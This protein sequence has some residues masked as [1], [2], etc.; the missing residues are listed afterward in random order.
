MPYPADVLGMETRRERFAGVGT[1]DGE[2]R[3]VTR[4]ASDLG[5]A[6]DAQELLYY[7]V[8]DLLALSDCL[9]GH[10]G[11]VR[12]FPWPSS[13]HPN[14]RWM[15]AGIA[16]PG[17]TSGKELAMD[18]AEPVRARRFALQY[19]GMRGDEHWYTVVDVR[20]GRRWG[21]YQ[22]H[23]ARH[24]IANDGLWLDGGV[25]AMGGMTRG[26]LVRLWRRA[27]ALLL[28]CS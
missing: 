11:H 1:W 25:P 18:E 19:E 21:P 15:H 7:D 13:H 17:G 26:W 9:R 16:V 8:R 27:R 3:R 5:M 10:T 24:I 14:C 22:Y 2:A 6:V 12:R 28:R 20:T 4:L 23:G